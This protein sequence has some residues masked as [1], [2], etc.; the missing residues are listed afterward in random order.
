MQALQ[1][2]NRKKRG[3]NFLILNHQLFFVFSALPGKNGPV[4]FCHI[5]HLPF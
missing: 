3:V 1:I 4:I 5:L 2:I